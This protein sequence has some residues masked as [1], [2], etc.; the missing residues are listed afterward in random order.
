MKNPEKLMIQITDSLV[1]EEDELTFT[2]SRSAGPGGQNVNKVNTRITL[3]FNVAA[4][5]CLSPEQKE[6]IRARLSTR[7]SKDGILRVVS[8]GSRSQLSNRDA[9][10][11]RFISLL[12]EV[13]TDLPPR[14]KTKA[15]RQA[16]AR[17]MD[18]KKIIGIKKK[19]RGRVT[20]PG[21]E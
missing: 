10:I 19:Q 15:S 2:A 21:E 5:P 6:R 3:W 1:I 8:Q 18:D 20:L 7:V 9:A 11:E 13:L 16:K 17:R 4:S 14:K 12:Q